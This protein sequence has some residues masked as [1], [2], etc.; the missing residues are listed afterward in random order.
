MPII[1]DNEEAKIMNDY[2]ADCLLQDFSSV[3]GPKN[4]NVKKIIQIFG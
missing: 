4:E 1:K 2:L 3:L